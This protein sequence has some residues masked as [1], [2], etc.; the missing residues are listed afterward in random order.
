VLICTRFLA[1]CGRRKDEA[2]A[3]VPPPTEGEEAAPSSADEAS[4]LYPLPD[5][6]PVGVSAVLD[7]RRPQVLCGQR[8][9]RF[10][11]TGENFK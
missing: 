11:A 9:L 8:W 3:M 6:A 7:R 4:A 2:L 1:L 10:G 5:I